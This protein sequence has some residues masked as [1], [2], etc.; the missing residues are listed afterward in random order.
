[1]KRTVYFRPE[2]ETEALE[3]QRWYEHRRPGLGARFEEAV[4]DAVAR[5]CENPAAFQRVQGEVR[6]AVLRR[7]PYAIY[8]RAEGD[9]II[10][11]AVHG[12]Q[13]PARWQTRG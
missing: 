9:D 4:G 2:A 5:M 12:R 10:V 11:L 1:M 8:F 6:R 3:S 13:D 7:F